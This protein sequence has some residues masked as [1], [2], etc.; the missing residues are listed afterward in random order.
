ML[1]LTSLKTLN[2]SK[3]FILWSITFINLNGLLSAHSCSPHH[4]HTKQL[5]VPWKCHIA[6]C[7]HLLV[8]HPISFPLLTRLKLLS[9]YQPPTPHGLQ[10]DWL[11][12][13]F[14]IQTEPWLAPQNSIKNSIL[15]TKHQLGQK[16]DFIWSSHPPDKLFSICGDDWVILPLAAF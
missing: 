5:A 12:L 10:G 15:Q 9:Q 4:S 13:Q 7:V 2:N 14:P 16:S 1:H 11:H 8:P 6:Y 3:Y